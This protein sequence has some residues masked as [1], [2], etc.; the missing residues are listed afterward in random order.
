MKNI[1]VVFLCFVFL[2]FYSCVPTKFITVKEYQAHG[3]EVYKMDSVRDYVHDSVFLYIHGDTVYKY[4]FQYRY[5]DRFSSDSVH[6]QD[7]IYREKIVVIKK[8]LTQW[9]VFQIWCGRILLLLLVL[10]IEF[11]LLKR[12][13]KRI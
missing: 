2:L 8:E 6:I 10:Y 7:T 1:A 12:Y 9:Q 11:K 3:R 5:I 4:Q 13:L